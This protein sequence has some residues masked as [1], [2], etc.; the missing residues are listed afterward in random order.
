[1]YF[2]KWGKLLPVTSWALILSFWVFRYVLLCFFTY[3]TNTAR[4]LNLCRSVFPS[5]M[6]LWMRK[7]PWYDA[8]D[9]SAFPLKVESCPRA[10]CF[11][12]QSRHRWKLAFT[13]AAHSD[14]F[15]D[16]RWFQE[17]AEGPEVVVA[18]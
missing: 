10:I 5:P 16:M 8:T 3:F 1:M 12:I 17:G 9:G 15:C 13:L 4:Q 6:A 14:R 7:Q 11:H 18:Q 2:F